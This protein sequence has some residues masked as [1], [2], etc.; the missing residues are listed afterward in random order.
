MTKVARACS[1]P[2]LDAK[3][4]S[5]DSSSSE[6]TS[7]AT[8]CSD[9][10]DYSGSGA[11]L[12]RANVWAR[13]HVIDRL[14]QR[15]LTLHAKK[16][17][18]CSYWVVSPDVWWRHP[19]SRLALPWFVMAIDFYVFAEDPVNDSYLDYNFVALGH[20]FHLFTTWGKEVEGQCFLNSCVTQNI[21]QV[22]VI[23]L[24]VAGGMYVGRQWVHHRFLRDWCE[25]PLFGYIPPEEPE[26]VDNT[27][28]SDSD[29]DPVNRIE[30]FVDAKEQSR[31]HAE[32]QEACDTNGSALIMIIFVCLFLFGG[33][34]VFNYT[35]GGDFEHPLSANTHISFCK[36]S[37]FF[38]AFS[39]FLDIQCIA[40]VTDQV[41]QDWKVYPLF[42]P[43][44]KE[45][46]T[47]QPRREANEGFQDYLERV[48]DVGGWKGARVPIFWS[49]MLGMPVLTT[50]VIYKTGHGYGDIKFLSTIFGGWTEVG[51]TYMLSWC[52]LMDLLVVAQDWDFPSFHDDVTINIGGT[53]VP[54]LSSLGPPACI[55]EFLAR[56]C[57]CPRIPCCPTGAQILKFLNFRM[58]GKWMTYLP[59]I[60][61]VLF[62]DLLC[63]K[64]QLAYA[65]EY[66]G[67]YVDS[68]YRVYTIMDR[69]YLDKIYVDGRLNESARHLLTYEARW[70]VTTR[71]PLDHSA[72]TDIMLN[73][74]F[75]HKK[76]L[77]AIGEITDQEL[78]GWL[79][80]VAFAVVFALFVN[81]GNRI[82]KNTFVERLRALAEKPYELLNNRKC[83][84]EDDD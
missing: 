53:F 34:V 13:H 7:S 61:A 41:L 3:V 38:Q 70:N 32:A 72:A 25:F 62:G 16:R 84:E 55:T 43:G 67:Q 71:Q 20:I 40:M 66:F 78:L 52:C 79:M 45:L 22:I 11:K 46:W 26:S 73:S 82:W 9:P 69:E 24:S 10:L 4:S 23:I 18:G 29:D 12:R 42:A 75:V 39:V 83:Q 6:S 50:C 60:L 57:T 58:T 76:F 44:L 21:L 54:Q 14:R 81:I 5:F 37:L 68:E 49:F 8:A 51:R 28:G 59:L 15:G 47:G 30:S 36:W 2:T 56:R 64:N 35:V 27:S 77:F 1:V 33:S 63:G 31:M 48:V 65:P 74:R 17:A 80:G 19:L